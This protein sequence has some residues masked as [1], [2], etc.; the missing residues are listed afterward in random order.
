MKTTPIRQ[1][2]SCLILTAILL[3]GGIS[4]G[5]LIN[6]NFTGGTAETASALS[7]P[8]GGLGT[9]WN[10]FAGPNSPGT[11]V[12]STGAATTVAI[13]SNFD[14]PNTF[15]GTVI[16]LPMLRG[17]MTNFGKGVDNT[18]VTISGLEAGGFYDIWM[19]TLRNQPFGSNGTEQYVGWWST[20]NGTTS[21]GNQLVNAV[22]AS[23]N[24][25]S[26]VAGYNYVL[27]E[28]V[29]AN[30]SG[31]IVFTGVAGPLLNGSNNNHRLGLNGL[32]IEKT[33]PPVAGVVDDAMSTVV[34]SPATV[35]A[36][37]VL[38]ST[39]TVTLRDANGTGVPGKEVTLAN[40]GGPQA[41]TINPLAAVSTNAAG[42][43]VF[44]ASSATP[45]IET[46]TATDVT[47]TLILTDTASVEFVEVGVLTDAARSTVVASPVARLAD[48][49]STSTI[50]VTLRDAN[51][52]P[53]S[54][55]NVTLANSGG[56]QAATISP[57]GAVVSDIDGQAVFSVGS[58]T[59]G[60]EQF[61]ATDTTDSIA[62]TQIAT[63]G[64]IDPNAPK[65]INVNFTGGQSPA[66]AETGLVG[67]AGGLLSS[68]N[69][70]NTTSSGP[71][72]DSTGVATSAA[73]S[74][75]D[76]GF[77]ALDAPAIDLTMLRGSFTNFG[78]GVD[79]TNVTISGLEAGGFYKVWLVTLRNQPFGAD[80]TEQ[81][82]GWWSTANATTSS[83]SQLVD[84]RG[85]VINTSTFVNSYNYVRFDNVEANGS[86]QIV[87]T[88]VAGPLQD[89][90]NNNHRLGLNGLQIEETGPPPLASY[91]TWSGGAPANGDENND[92]VQNAVAWVLG[93]AGPD[94]NAVGLLP[95][96]DNTTDPDFFIF[97]YRRSDAANADG[98][99]A[100]KV[101]Y[102]SDLANWTDAVAG[103]DIIITPY[104]DDYA[105][106][107]D[108]VEVKIRRTLAV[109]GK[110]FT[111]LNVVVT[112]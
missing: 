51:G 25:S 108:R 22:G 14:L 42:Q 4:H 105:A 26:F 69:Q 24:T 29:E 3:L 71:L 36:D 92:G 87:F 17:S 103:P 94:E 67:P 111:R 88:G 48:G 78:K 84:A 89:G 37:G 91:A 28:N 62:V 77:T 98:T 79:T 1:L 33:T 38:T 21:P 5:Q 49:L 45:G 31:N 70:L 72:V 61:T 112:P 8:G 97:N 52:F 59:I 16:A 109:G 85:A 30:G 44:N 65:L 95:S 99:T 10:Q 86:G 102:G 60:A 46:F 82:V 66:P 13:T 64:F 47:D 11:L 55:K 80:G 2:I 27:F 43:A 39:V 54:G 74:L 68:W 106:G 19:V 20:T 34:A 41:A 15:D 7:G 50:T 90:S 107:I 23:I 12:D 6:V 35:F 58:S 9:T 53:V 83:S 76:L 57:A 32:Q 18:S 63:V 96:L 104:N 56:I 100:I 81:Y 75:T 110:L 101:E 93:A 73:I 40:T